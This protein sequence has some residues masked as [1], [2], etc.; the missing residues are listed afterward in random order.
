MRAVV[1]RLEK[2]SGKRLEV[3][4]HRNRWTYFSCESVRNGRFVKVGLHE[5]F[6]YAPP[7][8]IAAVGRLIRREDAQARRVIREFVDSQSELWDRCAERPSRPPKI[9]PRG[10]VYDLREIFDELNRHYFGGRCSATITWGNGSRSVKGRRQIVFGYYDETTRI[11]RI[12]PALDRKSVPPYFV[13]YIVYHEMLHSVLPP[14]VSPA[15]RRIYHSREFRQR[16]RLFEDFHRAQEW[17]KRF[18]EKEIG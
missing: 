6:L 13:R 8:I 4:F 15:G 10:E 1:R 14:V 18:V 17:G 7:R 5:A 11:I 16:E 9:N 2:E 12:H 3:R